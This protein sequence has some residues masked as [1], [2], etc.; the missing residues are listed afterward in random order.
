MAVLASDF[1]S[2]AKQAHGR[3][4]EKAAR[5]LLDH[6]PQ[7]DR[8]QLDDAF[9][10][11]NLD[12]AFQAR[13]RF[14]WA[15]SVPEDLFL[16][17]VLPYAVVNETRETW[18]PNYFEIAGRIVEDAVTATEAAQKL[19]RDFFNAINVHYNTDREK[20]NQ[21]PAEST[22]QGKA[23]CTGLSI[24]LVDA[25]RAVGIPARI[26]GTPLWSNLRG[27][28][29][30]VEFWDN[31][32]H[33]VGADE[34][35]A[36]GVNRGWF[37]NDAAE[38]KEDDPRHAIYATSWQKTGT[39][40]PMAWSP[41]DTFVSGVNITSRY[42]QAPSKPE[43]RLG[44]R[45][46]ADTDQRIVV[47]GHLIAENG[48]LV[49][50][51]QTRDEGA[52]LNDMPEVVIE[53]GT[54]YRIQIKSQQTEL[55]TA[56]AGVSIM[57]VHA[58]ALAPIPDALTQEQANTQIAVAYAD[59]LADSRDTRQQE[60]D[61]KSITLG[62]H[63]LAWK[64]KTFGDEPEN[65][66]SLWISM[67][68]GGGAP[69]EVNNS[70]WENQV[71]LYQPNEGIY[72]APR[73]PTDTWNLWH[74]AHIDPLFDRLIEN[75]IALGNVDPDKVYL[76]G[77]SAGG[78]GVWQLAPRMA[79]RFAAAAMMAGHPNEASVIGLRNLPFAIF[80]G[81]DDGGYNRNAVAAEKAKQLND[82]QKEDAQGYTHMARVY[83]GLGHW[84]NRKDAEALPW[85]AQF[86]RRSWPTR[87]VWYQDDVTHD[88]F[89]WLKLPKNAA[90]QGD[91]IVAEIE[92]QDIRIEGNVPP[93]MRI[94]LSDKLVDLDH[95]V[96]VTVNGI[97]EFAGRPK[98]RLD[99]TK[100]TLAERLD[101]SIAACAEIVLP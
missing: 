30:W 27:N 81:A 72:I 39:V 44:V 41:E 38:A 48:R 55:F 28:H 3:E 63:T 64:A 4:G 54:R 59:R 101:P 98:R 71:K 49:A 62:E 24:I 93:G 78:D 87:I 32:W 40:F 58:D 74:E 75:Y 9:L 10:F 23:S 95:E 90:A 5:F 46:F 94:R 13:A 67:H 47:T 19:N 50:T 42:V 43:H 6:M 11:E 68:G 17:D 1:I 36:Q 57:D 51:F 25:C 18:R 37:V 56:E 80:V 33:F 65:G 85:M 7:H 15:A 96:T 20:A 8:A 31:G 12:L 70:Q 92:G 86:S 2:D 34:Y 100:D 29:T 35:D 22:R 84:M 89:Y 79:D 73:A 99:V 52:D 53:P 88:R 16:N 76:M 77:Y 61:A 21:S 45:Y 14:P 69:K 82:L 91:T 97:Q 26:V 66:H 60:L 83:E